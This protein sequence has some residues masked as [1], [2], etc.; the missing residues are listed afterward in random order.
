MKKIILIVFFGLTAN[1][2]FAQSEAEIEEM[3]LRD[4]LI[5]ANATLEMDFKTVLKYTHPTILEKSG[6]EEVMLKSISEMFETLK[7]DQGFIFEK[8]EVLGV[9][10]L[11]QED[12]EYRCLVENKNQMVVADTRIFSK[13]YL[14]GFYDKAKKQWYFL[15]AEKL[16]NQALIDTFFPG[17]KTEIIIPND[18]VTTEKIEK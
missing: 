1:T 4:A 17:F 5:A 15:E 6:G 10:N 18:V 9:S 13:S 12:G 8:S 2:F 16:K 14:F 3:A 11:T 7:K